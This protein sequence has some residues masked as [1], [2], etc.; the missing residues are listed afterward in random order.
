MSWHKDVQDNVIM[1]R[2]LILLR[3]AYDNN[4]YDHVPTMCYKIGLLVEDNLITLNEH[5][6][7]LMFF[8]RNLPKPGER[9][10]HNKIHGFDTWPYSNVKI[11][12]E[13]LNYKIEQ[14]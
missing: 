6:T 9:F 11:R 3:N 14:L 7:L 8:K 10:Y 1:K 12:K 2:L 13:W 4:K 5:D